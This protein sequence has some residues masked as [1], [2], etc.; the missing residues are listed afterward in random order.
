MSQD[1]D[2]PTLELSLSWGDY[3]QETWEATAEQLRPY[4]RVGG[5]LAIELSEAELIPHKVCVISHISGT[6]GIGLL[7]N[8]LWDALK[9]LFSRGKE[10][11][12]VRIEIK[13]EV[14]ES[15]EVYRQITTDDP[16]I[17]QQS[18]REVGINI[19]RA[20]EEGNND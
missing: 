9:D 19:A 3:D 14:N 15:K 13:V 4:F 8:A 5:G 11:Q 6:I 10:N 16:K 2:K 18:L 7:T 1:A 20:T 17:L 12:P